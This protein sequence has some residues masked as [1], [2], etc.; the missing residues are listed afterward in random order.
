MMLPSGTKSLDTSGVRIPRRWL[1]LARM[2]WVIIVIP[3]FVLFVANIPAYFAALHHLPAPG[4]H[5]ISGQLTL[6]DR[7]TLQTWGL[8][9][10]FY[11]VC[12]VVVSLLFQVS[13]T[14]M[15]AVLFWRRSDDRVALLASFALPMLP[16]GFASLTLQALPPAWLWLIP[17]LSAFGNASIMLCA[18]IFPDGRFVP[19]WVR[20]LALFMLAYWASSALLPSWP[21]N[22]FI[23][24]FILLS[25][26]ASTIFVQVYRYRYVSSPQQ[27]QQTKWVVYGIAIAATGNIG[28]RLLHA[29]VLVPSASG[30]ALPDAFMVILVTCSMLVIPP[31]IGIAILRSH[32]WDIDV[33]IKRTLVYAVLTATLALVY[34][35][36]I[37]VLQSLVSVI[38]GHFSLWSQSPLVIVASTLAIAALFQPLRRRIQVIIDRRFYRARYDAAHTLAAF[39]ATLRNEVDLNQLSEQLVGMVQE[40]MQPEHVTLWLRPLHWEGKK[41]T[42]LL[43][44]LN[45]DEGRG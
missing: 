39:S 10:D 5:F 14:A 16:F 15:G 6:A 25:L 17:A 22:Q 18:Y 31:T 4:P 42:R 35:G 45:E 13:Y 26:T 37:V 40:T 11:A 27:R 43:P 33:I 12:M 8:S 36:S 1:V 19:G 3:A 20:W 29:F 2:A 30:S 38:T 34:F 41:T 9:L 21:F 44:R 23:Y 28:A 24:T 32:L 7:H